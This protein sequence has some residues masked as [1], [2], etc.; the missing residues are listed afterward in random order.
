MNASSL[1]GL[2]LIGGTALLS[3]TAIVGGQE[4]LSTRQQALN[5]KISSTELWQQYRWSFDPQQRR[6]A[7]L[8]LAAQSKDSPHRRQ[9]LLAGQGWG[10]SPLAAVALKLQA[11]T[12]ERLGERS[13]ATQRWRVLLQRFP[14]SPVSADAYYYLG[15]RQPELHQ[16]LL[17]L[18]P[19]HPAAL[20][21]AVEQHHQAISTNQ[22]ALHLARW[23]IRWPGARE[24]FDKACEASTET[25]ANAAQRQQLSRALAQLGDGPAAL[26]CLR[27]KPADP[28]TALAMGQALLSGDQEEQQQGEE[29]LLLLAQ[30]HPNAPES[31]EAAKLLSEPFHPNADRLAAL[32]KQLIARSPSVNAARTRLQQGRKAEDVMQRWPDSPESWQLQWDLAREALLQKQWNQAESLLNLIPTKQL[33]EPLAARQQFWQGLAVD[34]QGRSEEATQI[35]EQLLRSHPAGYYT[36]RAK[37][38]LRAAELP[39]LQATGLT[40][41]PQP[42]DWRPLASGSE[43]VDELWRLGLVNEAWETWRNQRHLIVSETNHP[44]RLIIE[45]RLRMAVGDHWTGLNQLWRASLRLIGESCPTRELLHRSQHPY[46][47]WPA[48]SEA[49]RDSDVRPE[50]LLAIAKQESRFSAN[51]QSIAGAIGLMQ[52]MPATAAELAGEPLT[53]ED[54]SMPGISATLGSRYLAALLERWHGNPWLTVASYNAGPNAVAKWNSPELSADPELWVE[55]IPY[56]ETRLYTKKVLGNLW[57]YLQL[58]RHKLCGPVE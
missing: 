24:V 35:W 52:L 13:K 23:G 41:T 37:S 58:D 2:S 31:L 15:R 25:T 22:A 20:A 7:A 42:E 21:S 47:F 40:T 33:P 28:A 14:S 54:L 48:I 10:G 46:R 45:G 29:Q 39:S 1:R 12:A 3:L 34:K 17:K 18:H 50:L 9:R 16:Q 4:L 44:E 6:E 8:L 57:S 26:N 55:R 51:V 56:P 32:P 38:R 53:Q 36:W 30:Q 49:S 27:G 11:Q 43:L 5:P 19:A